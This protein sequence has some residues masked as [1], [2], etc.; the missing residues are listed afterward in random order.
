MT[1]FTCRIAERSA[2]KRLDRVSQNNWLEMGLL[3]ITVVTRS[4]ATGQIGVDM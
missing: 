3:T 2:L 4:N 1:F